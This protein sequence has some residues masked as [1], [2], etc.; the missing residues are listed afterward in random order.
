MVAINVTKLDMSEFLHYRFMNKSIED[1][2]FRR[3]DIA[4]YHLSMFHRN[5]KRSY[6][7]FLPQQLTCRGG[8]DTDI[9][10]LLDPT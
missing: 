2:W 3:G 10:C 1:D 5:N 8:K 9:K 6:K 7:I 4:M